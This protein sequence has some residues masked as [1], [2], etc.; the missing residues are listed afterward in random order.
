M[1]IFPV[2]DDSEAAAITAALAALLASGGDD[3][4]PAPPDPRWRFSNRWW[5]RPTPLVRSRP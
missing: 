3:D 2:P 4:E 5:N 1:E